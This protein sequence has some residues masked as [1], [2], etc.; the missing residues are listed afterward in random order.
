MCDSYMYIYII[1]C[2]IIF[3]SSYFFNVQIYT[4]SMLY[5]VK[6]CG[7]ISYE[8]YSQHIMGEGLLLYN[9]M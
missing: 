9:V 3:N 5:S 4:Q 7:Q 1:I 2:I 8:T 6:S